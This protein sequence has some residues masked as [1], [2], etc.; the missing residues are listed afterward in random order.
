MILFLN[1]VGHSLHRHSYLNIKMHKSLFMA[2]LNVYL[3]IFL[4]L[5]FWVFWNDYSESKGC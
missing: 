1:L 2:L 3:L 5:N 4:K